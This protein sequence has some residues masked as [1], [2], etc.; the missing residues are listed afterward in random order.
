MDIKV[1]RFNEPFKVGQQLSAEYH[2]RFSAIVKENREAFFVTMED[3]KTPCSCITVEIDTGDHDPVY[4]APY[5][6]SPVEDAALAAITRNQH[7]L[8]IVEPSFS[9]WGSPAMVVQKKIPDGVDPL[10]LPVEQRWRQVI[11][12][13]RLNEVVQPVNM[14]SLTVHECLEAAASGTFYSR[15]DLVQA[16][17][18]LELAEADRHKTCFFTNDG[19]WHAWQFCRMP[20]GLRTAP[21]YFIKALQIALGP[22]CAKGIVVT[23]MDDLVIIG[24]TVEEHLENIAEVL[25][26]LAKV[27]LL[28]APHK[29]VFFMPEIKFLGHVIKEGKIM[30]DPAKVRAIKD[31]PRPSNPDEVRSFLGLTTCYMRNQPHYSA[32]SAPLRRLLK[33]D[34]EWLWKEDE[35]W[36]FQDL[37]TKGSNM[38]VVHAPMFDKMFYLQTDYSAIALAAILSQKGDGEDEHIIACA[39][40]RCTPAE[41]RLGATAGELQALVYGI[42]YFHPYLFGRK[43]RVETDHAALSFLHRFKANQSKLARIAIMLQ[44]YDFEVVYK[45][46]YM[47]TNAD[48]LSRTIPLRDDI[49]HRSPES[50]MVDLPFGTPLLRGGS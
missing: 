1:E 17:W 21:A 8:G 16:Y 19:G 35:E 4:H 32:L 47:N 43:F 22:A 36:T 20:Q 39:S 45:R 29:C 41:S 37:K 2:G 6:R 50:S 23:F 40:R 14:P 5:R 30:V 3:M 38:P 33:K 18:Q 25:G 11:D 26:L 24:K 10:S 9:A 31:F 46:G 15:L 28:A 12:L 42:G 27:H 7:K 34:V 44:D 48:C 13:R 49:E